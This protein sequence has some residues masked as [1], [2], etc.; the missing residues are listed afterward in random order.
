[1]FASSP[2]WRLAT[3]ST[4]VPSMTR[5]VASAMPVSVTSASGTRP[6]L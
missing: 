6:L 4:S 5:E 3:F 1:M 2:G